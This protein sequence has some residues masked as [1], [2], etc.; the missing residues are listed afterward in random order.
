ME[1]REES[2]GV[3]GAL[4]PLDRGD[5]LRDR[6]KGSS[7]CRLFRLVRLFRVRDYSPT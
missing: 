5:D 3:L 4:R 1:E 7:P 6:L 2:L